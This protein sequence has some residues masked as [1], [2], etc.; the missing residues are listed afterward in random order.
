MTN[1]GLVRVIGVVEA[2]SA[3]NLFFVAMPLKYLAAMPKAVT[4]T[5]TV[6]GGL[7]IL[8]ALVVFVA[9]QRGKLTAKW[10]WILGAASFVRGRL[11]IPSATRLS[12][13]ASA[14]RSPSAN[15]FSA[16]SVVPFWAPERFWS[17]T[18]PGPP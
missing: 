17:N 16:S 14:R 13:S 2:V 12:R 15:G 6:H 9:W 18:N 5:G 4:W 11:A 1:L 3:I 7:W 10:F 8:Y